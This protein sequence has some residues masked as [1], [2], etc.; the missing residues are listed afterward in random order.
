MSKIV[1]GLDISESHWNLV[2]LTMSSRDKIC[3]EGHACLY[4]PPFPLKDLLDPDLD[5]PVFESNLFKWSEKLGQVFGPFLINASG[6][7]VGIPQ[8]LASVRVLEVPFTQGS[9]I[10][11]VLPYEAEASIPF[12]IEDLIFDYLPL[13]QV[14]G[15]TRL[16][17]ASISRDA[18]AG[19]LRH[20][21]PMGLDP[22]VIAPSA[23]CLNLLPGANGADPMER[24]RTA[25]LNVGALGSQLS[26]V[27]AGRT[28]FTSHFRTG[29]LEMHEEPPAE[30]DAEGSAE[31]NE[32]GEPEAS[33]SYVELGV[34][35]IISRLS[36]G[37]K[38]AVHHLEG[39]APFDH[40]C[41]PPLRRIWLT[42]EGAGL[43]GLAD[44]LSREIEIS[45]ERFALPAA[46]LSED[47]A[48]PGGRDAELAPA[49]AL[50][51]QKAMP[52]A[53]K[54]INF[55]KQEFAF[56]PERRELIRKMIF[57]ALL[58]VLM[59][60]VMGVRASI[61]GSSEEQVVEQIRQE[62]A[63]DFQKEFPQAA[64]VDP[65]RQLKQMLKD[66]KAKQQKYQDLSY[67]TALEIL[68]AISAAAPEE[69]NVTVTSF[70]FRNDKAT[71]SGDAE[72]L[73]EPNEL[74][75]KLS[76]V[77]I[78]YK[79]DLQDNRKVSETDYRFKISISMKKEA[80]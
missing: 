52:Q 71:I 48:S 27:E 21:K 49:V 5:D 18:I 16:L 80:Q 64:V 47:S 43:E 51:M 15:G 31:E 68:A 4:D 60:V 75:K 72:K 24:G 44:G 67:P 2:A 62:M 69:L 79:A 50:A 20:L 32:N 25:F 17:T 35:D 65:S 22:M 56:H 76:Q 55:R 73:E 58:L 29:M 53:V 38:W 12:D 63:A 57:P 3:I 74:A 11:K 77:P 78:L 1:I 37:L 33:T 45:T 59:F 14:D 40:G 41:P 8:E 28:I 46:A 23:M 10:E 30:A 42:G 61:S 66:V 9:R 7:I 70:D 36:P 13:A 34:E 54:G 39:F 6:A 19:L 26:V